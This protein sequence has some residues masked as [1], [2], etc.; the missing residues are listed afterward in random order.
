MLQSYEAIYDHG[1][2]RWLGDSPPPEK[3]RVIV[4]LLPPQGQQAP[5][6]GR[7]PSPR[8][9]GKGRILGDIIAPAASV[10]EWDLLG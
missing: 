5:P 3:S 7:V 10:D 6:F 4:T 2:I 1:Q 8:V 9:A